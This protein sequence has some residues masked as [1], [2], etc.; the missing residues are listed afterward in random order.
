MK[1]RR[2]SFALVVAL[3][4]PVSLGAQTEPPDSET[5]LEAI[6]NEL[7]A[8]KAG[9]VEAVNEQDIDKMLSFLAEDVVATWQNSEVFR[10]HEGVREFFGRVQEASKKTFLGYAVPPTPDDLTIL[11]DNR[12]GISFGSSTGRYKVAGMQFEMENRW[13]A[14]LVKQGGRWLVASY[15]VSTNLLDNP[16][17]NAAKST[18]IWGIGIAF[19]AGLVVSLLVVKLLAR[20][21]AHGTKS[22]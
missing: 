6:H 14:T 15:H 21:K 19:L 13:S 10:G 8:L 18:M 2:M 5:D 22:T 1:N 11:Y 4:L 17:L 9:L 20:K 16:V 7:R 3:L 12:T